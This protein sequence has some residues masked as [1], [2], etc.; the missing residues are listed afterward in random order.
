MP[1]ALTTRYR[2]WRY[3]IFAV[4]W[5]TYAGF[6][7]CR[8]NFSIAMPLLSGDLGCTKDDFAIVLFLYSLF[9]ALGQFYNGF[10]SDR[11]GPRLI[12]GTPSWA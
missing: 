6:Y 2:L 9:Y 7:L 4:L 11:F 1:A 8:K 3:R 12:V 5:L 10:L